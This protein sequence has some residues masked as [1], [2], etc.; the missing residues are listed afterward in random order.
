MRNRTATQTASRRSRRSARARR[1]RRCRPRPAFQPDALDRRRLDWVRRR[2]RE[3]F[4]PRDRRA[5]ELH[6]IKG[7]SYT[8]CAKV[9][10]VHPA[11]V[12]RRVRHTIGR[13]RREAR[14]QP[15]L[16]DRDTAADG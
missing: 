16:W 2:L 9:L 10:R 3:D 6:F 1:A 14:Q 7:R 12:S 11:T 8:D 5:I 4:H 13:L 15:E